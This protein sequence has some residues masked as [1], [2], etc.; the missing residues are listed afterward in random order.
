[1]SSYTFAEGQ[2]SV[3]V[4][5]L[6]LS[7]DSAEEITRGLAAKSEWYGFVAQAVAIT[8][9][10]ISDKL[11]PSGR[12][13]LTV[14]ALC[15]L[16]LAYWAKKKQRGPF[17]TGP[18][19]AAVWMGV[20]VLMPIVLARLLVPGEYGASPPCVQMCGYPTAPL[21][22]FAFFP[23]GFPG[24][25]WKRTH[26]EILMLAI[27]ILEPLGLIYL[28][29][30]SIQRPNLLAVALAALWNL[31]AFFAGKE[32]RKL[33]EA[34]ARAQF[35]GIGVAYVWKKELLHGELKAAG[36]A[37]IDLAR[38]GR[39]DE[40]EPR[41]VEVAKT[42][43]REHDQ[44]ETAMEEVNILKAIRHRVREVEPSLHE[45]TSDNPEGP[46]TVP[47]PAGK[48]I[49]ETITDL[50]NNVIEHGGKRAHVVFRVD[51]DVAI[52]VVSDHGKGVSPKVV[53]NEAT[54]LH[55]LRGKARE[56]GGDLEV[57]TDYKEGARIRLYVPLYEPR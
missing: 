16:L 51:Q 14:F 26:F 46:G 53:Q 43:S 27:V 54:K 7:R 5:P 30:G 38:Q 28:I 32:L 56:L 2:P 39:F 6:P 50:L 45:V 21:I 18:P 10:I 1:M 37:A 52:L 49:A 29:N 34:A 40:I 42:F 35:D 8:A 47:Q 12:I 55:E 36:R 17:A 19:W 48:L 13:F 20:I 57:M 44:I 24:K 11:Q 22:L 4:G 33:C 3:P 25:R 9:S 31:L 41:L 15:H 23:W